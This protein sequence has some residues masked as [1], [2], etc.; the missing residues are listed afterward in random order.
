MG[1]INAVR[2]MGDLEKGAGFEQHLKFPLETPG[3][4]IR[5]F[6]DIENVMAKSLNVMG[7]AKIDL[8]DLSFEPEMKLKYLWRDRVGSNVFWGFTPIYRAGRPL[9][10]PKKRREAYFG[11]DGNWSQNDKCH[12]NKIKLRIL[13]DYEKEGTFTPGSVERIMSQ[14]PERVDGILDQLVDNKASH[15]II[16]GG[17]RGDDFLYPGEIPAFIDYFQRKLDMTLGAGKNGAN[18]KMSESA[19]ICSLC[20]QRGGE[21]TTLD[22]IFKFA[23]FDKV[24]ILP[25]L[26]EAEQGSVF[27]VC[28]DCIAK[29]AAG[30]SHI[31]RNLANS[32]AIPGIRI[33]VIP[34]GPDDD[35][36]R[37]R[38][39]VANLEKG[40]SNDKL[41]NP[42]LHTEESYFRRLARDGQGLIFHFVFWERNNSQ[43]LVHLMV[44][45]V[46]PERL[47]YLEDSWRKALRPIRPEVSREASLDL[48]VDSLY[49]TLYTLGGKSKSDRSVFRGFVLDI[50]GHLLAG[51]E[52]PIQA[53]KYFVVSRIPRLIH[54]S[55]R[56][57]DVTE[58]I[59]YALAWVEFMNIVSKG[60]R[61]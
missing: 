24:S 33:W 25:G 52:P 45:D 55:E 59:A 43:E 7:V 35:N 30:R 61:V 51:K 46:P 32:S 17:M 34:E 1:F 50:L 20:G 44:E 57:R 47:A 26:E 60:G 36:V 14:L 54:E 27:P 48:A 39:L 11:E 41:G 4:M 19:R 6:L 3:K 16:F 49:R 10:D 53:F 2:Q 58:T 38:G 23:T 42:G 28:A 5:V 40:I 21:T 8:A 9:A 15:I 56:W 18:S 31:D 13:D 29:L 12:L 37:F 22:K